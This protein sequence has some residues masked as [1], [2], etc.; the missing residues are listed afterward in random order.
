MVSVGV[1]LTE[2]LTLLPLLELRLWLLHLVSLAILDLVKAGQQVNQGEQISEMG[3]TGFST[4]PHVHFE[5]HPGG[6]GA[7][8]PIA[9]LPSNRG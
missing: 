6:K 7:V 5:V 1:V 2:G 9:Y 4:G 8:N 3:S